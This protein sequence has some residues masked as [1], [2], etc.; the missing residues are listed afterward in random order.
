MALV[1]KVFHQPL[2]VVKD[3]SLT[4]LFTWAKMAAAMEGKDFD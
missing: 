1:M 2:P 4:E 3:M